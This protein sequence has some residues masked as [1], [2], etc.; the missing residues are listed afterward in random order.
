MLIEN[1]I[2]NETLEQELSWNDF[3][4]CLAANSISINNNTDTA[5]KGHLYQIIICSGAVCSFYT[6]LNTAVRN[7][8]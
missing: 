8:C 2:L 5:F 3:S 4:N 7:S 6:M 1:R